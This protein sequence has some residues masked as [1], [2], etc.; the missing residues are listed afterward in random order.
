MFPYVDSLT[1]KLDVICE[2]QDLKVSD[3]FDSTTDSSQAS[4]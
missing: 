4:P 1:H 3:S 2:I